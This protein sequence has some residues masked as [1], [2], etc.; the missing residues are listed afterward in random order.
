MFGFGDTPF[1][2]KDI[3]MMEKVAEIISVEE[4]DGELLFS[5]LSAMIVEIKMS[6][7]KIM[8]RN[9][10]MEISKKTPGHCGDQMLVW[11]ELYSELLKR[12]I[13]KSF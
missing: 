11:V 7:T 10:T 8:K 3:I 9:L 1:L 13:R 2:E 6:W 5:C 12:V 4:G